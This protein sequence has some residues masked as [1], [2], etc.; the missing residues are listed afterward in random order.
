MGF[1]LNFI[2]H[3]WQQVTVV[4]LKNGLG[5]NVATGLEHCAAAY[6][7]VSLIISSLSTADFL[8]LP[9]F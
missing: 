9:I 8:Q 7:K 2:V 1:F 3:S 6:G 5:V 4:C